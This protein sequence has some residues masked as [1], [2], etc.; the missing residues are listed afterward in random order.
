MQQYSADFTAFTGDAIPTIEQ[1]AM[2]LLYSN[3]VLGENATRFYIAARFA[4]NGRKLI[5]TYK[6]YIGIGP[7]AL[8][9]GDTVCV[10]VGGVTLFLLRRDLRS[11]LSKRRFVLVGETYIHSIM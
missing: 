6:G 2:R 5:L 7:A 3:R 8:Q 11:Q 4:C 1:H 9:T 10:L